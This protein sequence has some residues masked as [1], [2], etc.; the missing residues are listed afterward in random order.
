MF[1]NMADYKEY[2]PNYLAAIEKYGFT[3]N[4]M[5]DDEISAFWQINVNN[6]PFAGIVA[7]GDCWT[8]SV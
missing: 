8:K 6:L 1:L 7:R 3:S 5:T 4:V 2:M